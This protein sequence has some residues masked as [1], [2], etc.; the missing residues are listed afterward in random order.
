MSNDYKFCCDDCY[1]ELVSMGH[2]GIRAASLWMELCK[3]MHDQRKM[4]IDVRQDW[5]QRQGPA[6]GILEDGG[7]AL[8]CDLPRGIRIKLY[9][10]IDKDLTMTYCACGGEHDE[11]YL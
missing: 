8:S 7:F 2:H 10:F 4:F 11:D 3:I 6:L 5:E 9:G 1:L